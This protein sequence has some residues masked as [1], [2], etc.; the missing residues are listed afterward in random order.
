[1]DEDRKISILGCTGSIGQNTIS[2]IKSGTFEDKSSFSALPGN[3]N[4]Y[5]LVKKALEL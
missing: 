1:M 2:V 5:Q 4:L 3:D